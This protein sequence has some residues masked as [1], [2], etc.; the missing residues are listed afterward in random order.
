MIPYGHQFIDSEDIAA[1]DCG[2]KKVLLIST[3]KTVTSAG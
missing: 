2:V 1:I 3:D